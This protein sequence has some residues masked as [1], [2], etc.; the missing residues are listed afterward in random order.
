MHHDVFGDIVYNREDQEWTGWCSLPAFAQ[1][2][3]LAADNH[4]LSEPP[5]EFERGLFALSIQDESGGGPSNEQANALRH[6]VEH[7]TEVCQTVVAELVKACDQQGGLLR[8]LNQRRQSR[9]WGWLAKLAG[10][11]YKTP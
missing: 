9:L 3:R 5:P 6:L 10:P 8:W 11:E 7:E 4:R 1:Y 2:G